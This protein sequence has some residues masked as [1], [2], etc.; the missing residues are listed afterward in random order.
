MNIHFFDRQF[1]PKRISIE[2]VF[3]VVK[4]ELIKK[5]YSVS[6]FDNPFPLSKM[7]QAMWFFRKNQGDINHITGDIHW[8]CLLLNSNRTVLTIHDNVGAEAYSST[9]KNKLYRLIWIYLPLWKLK[10]V[11]VISQKTKDE[12]L[13]YYPAAAKKI[14]V[15][16]NPLTAELYRRGVTDKKAAD[17]QSLLVGTRSNK[18]IE[19]VLIATSDLTCKIVIV[20]ETDDVQKQLI[21]ESNAEISVRS[22]ISDAE[23]NNIYRSSDILVFPSLYEGFGMP[24]IEAQ[25]AGCA[26]ITSGIEP[27][28]SVAA[29]AALFVDPLD[30][31]AIEMQIKLLINDLNLRRDLVEKGYANA[32]RFLPEEITQQYI[33]LYKEIADEAGIID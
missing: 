21:N 24:I 30:T 17:I 6:S 15:I 12:L 8:A 25:A 1:V 18:N 31:K 14:R 16:H 4:S 5:N 10:Y 2:K 11:T 27:M 7:L 28:N 32:K 33:N 19:R 13:K 3:S 26:V 22:F 23:L 20:G 9:L 29:D